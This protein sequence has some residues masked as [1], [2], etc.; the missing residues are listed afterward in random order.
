MEKISTNEKKRKEITNLSSYWT[1]KLGS[2]LLF[3]WTQNLKLKPACFLPN[4]SLLLAAM[5]RRL[6]QVSNLACLN[7]RPDWNLHTVN[8][9]TCA[10][11]RR[12]KS[13]LPLFWRE[14]SPEREAKR[15]SVSCCG[16]T[17][18]SWLQDSWS[19]SALSASTGSS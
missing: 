11:M 9:R 4:R 16:N 15:E 19:D 12:Y 10:E 6:L 18:R 1:L 7:V 5:S 2:L 8:L 3:I 13:T 17:V 14:I